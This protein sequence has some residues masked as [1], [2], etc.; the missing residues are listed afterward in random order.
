LY[1]QRVF[2]K[3]GIFGKRPPL[4]DR[5]A[6]KE[7]IPAKT[8]C[9]ETFEYIKSVIGI[10]LGLSLAKLLQSAVKLVQH[11][12]RTKPYWG[13]LLWALYLFLLLVL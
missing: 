5:S 3:I 9:M 2:A 10:I 7:A 6:G 12:S 11:P 13:H 4:R 8:N 1:Y